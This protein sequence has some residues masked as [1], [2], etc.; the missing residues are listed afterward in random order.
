[1]KWRKLPT[2]DDGAFA[3]HP[4]R[5]RLVYFELLRHANDEGEIALRNEN[6]E[7]WVAISNRSSGAVDITDRRTLKYAIECLE[8]AGDIYRRGKV[9]VLRDW[10][11]NQGRKRSQPG[12]NEGATASSGGATEVERES[13]HGRVVVEPESNVRATDAKPSKSGQVALL[14][15]KR[16][17]EE[18][19]RKEGEETLPR[20]SPRPPAKPNALEALVSLFATRWEKRHGAPYQ[21]TKGDRSQLSAVLR[22]F[23]TA[24]EA[25]EVLSACFDAYLADTSPF[26]AGEQGHSLRWF[27]TSG[28]VNKYRTN[29]T[30]TLPRLTAA[31]QQAADVVARFSRGAT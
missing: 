26:V 7:L 20:L 23:A 12:S 18:E 6:D 14:E 9:Y 17:E 8:E 3:D 15:E 13:N 16:I 4:L 31:E 28:G 2:R 19:K 30:P 29:R 22:S 10:E 11:R 25:L 5:V 24:T 27:C 21:A 1:M